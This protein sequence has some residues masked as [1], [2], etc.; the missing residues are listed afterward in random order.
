M[1]SGG[2][3]DKNNYRKSEKLFLLI[4][5][6]EE[7]KDACI[8]MLMRYLAYIFLR[9]ASVSSD[10]EA[11]KKVLMSDSLA[12][13]LQYIHIDNKPQIIMDVSDMWLNMI[14]NEGDGRS[15]FQ[16]FYNVKCFHQ[17]I[18]NQ[19]LLVQYLFS[20]NHSK[21]RCS[22]KCISKVFNIKKSLFCIPLLMGYFS[23]YEKKEDFCGFIPSNEDRITTNDNSE[24]DILE[25]NMP[26][27]PVSIIN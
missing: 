5:Y 19:E 9:I 24:H 14:R 26:S 10:D 20:R 16:V 18:Q 11:C 8:N 7:V 1:L 13:A 6:Q 17:E 12:N 25:S 2:Y 27:I 3:G 4:N 15:M 23:D 22:L 21:D